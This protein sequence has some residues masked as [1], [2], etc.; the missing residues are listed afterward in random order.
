MRFDHAPPQW[1]DDSVD[2]RA[3]PGDV[4]DIGLAGSGSRDIRAIRRSIFALLK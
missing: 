3:F 2:D 1:Q 4:A